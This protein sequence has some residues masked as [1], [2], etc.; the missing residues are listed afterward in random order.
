M[1][2][3]IAVFACV[4]LAEGIVR[5]PMHKHK[6]MR[7][8]LREKGIELHYQDPALKYQPD[9]FSTSANMY[10]NNYADTTYYGAISIGTP[11]QSFQ[12]L[13]DTGSAN[14][15][16]DSVY[17]TTEACNAHTK[18][19]PQQSSTY[20]A[21]GQTFY[22]PYGAGS[23]YGTFGYDTV[24]VGGIVINNQEI[25]LS[26]NEPGQNFVY[27]KFD[28]IL[29]L[30]YPSI[31]AGGETPVMD[32]MISQNLLGADIFAFY[33]S[34]GGQQGSV[35][36]FGGY[37]TSLY[38]G[39]IYWTPVTSETYWQIGVQ[40]FQINGEETGWCSQGCQSVVDT[41]TSTLTAPSQYIGYIMQAIGAQQNQYGMYTV[42]CSQVNNLPTLSFVISGVAL[43]LPPSAYINQNGDQYCT[44]NIAPTYL[45]SRNG[46]PLW[47]F[48]D[49][50]LREYYSIYDRTY[51]RVGFASAA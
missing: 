13:F 16:V 32:N 18:F 19:N 20:S 43:A 31:S 22:L 33:L 10:I 25:G 35:L 44:V 24:N 14:L 4:V 47:I 51:N 15:W 3:L 50:F 21:K 9:E 40:G 5:V 23:L 6:S 42:D 1:K 39:Q 41:G 38:Q 11:P 37:D 48:G 36:S 45:P 17:C 27:A 46:Q 29:G 7:E 2:C 30:S 28:G 8:A 12:V 26:T 34:R 49:V